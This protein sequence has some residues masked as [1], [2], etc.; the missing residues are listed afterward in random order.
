MNHSFCHNM[1]HMSI[2][3]VVAALLRRTEH[4]AG[5][6]I[7]ADGLTEL[8]QGF[9]IKNEEVIKKIQLFQ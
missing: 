1:V 8:P 4:S 6:R 5:M 3:E 2:S 7:S 9:G